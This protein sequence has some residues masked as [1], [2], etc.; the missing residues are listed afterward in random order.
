MAFLTFLTLWGLLAVKNILALDDDVAIFI[1]LP[2]RINKRIS[3]NHVPIMN[4][5]NFIR[6]FTLNKMN[7]TS[8]SYYLV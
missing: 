8:I 6:Y 5:C 2:I 3:T 1:L 7:E 4:S